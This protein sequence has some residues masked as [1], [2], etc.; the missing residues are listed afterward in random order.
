M[1]TT[2]ITTLVAAALAAGTIGAAAPASAVAYEGQARSAGST[3]TSTCSWVLATYDT[4]QLG[5]RGESVRALQ[6]L[7]NDLG[8][9]VVVDGWYGPQT[10]AAVTASLPQPP[11]GDPEPDV[12]YA[13]DWLILMATAIDSGSLKRGERGEDVRLLQAALRIN[14]IQIVVD[15]WY[16][17]QTAQAVRTYQQMVGIVVD[18]WAGPQTL[19]AMRAG[20]MAEG[21]W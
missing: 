16:G 10:L 13:N 12:V 4:L 6:C 14:N 19:G 3:A 1:N 5:D 17:P 7:L 8:H 21:C 20:W 9:H 18:G 11:E 15:G 2:R